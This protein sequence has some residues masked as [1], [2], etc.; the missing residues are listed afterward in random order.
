[1]SSRPPTIARNALP[2]AAWPPCSW[3]YVSS[4]SRSPIRCRGANIRASSTTATTSCRPTFASR[5]SGCSGV[6]CIPSIGWGGQW[7]YG[8][9]SWTIDYPRGDRHIAALVR[10]L[11]I[12]DARSVEQ[13]VNLDDG[14]DVF[15]W[16]WL[17]AVEV[18][19]GI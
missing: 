17:Y 11:S 8:G 15:N 9:T 16:P 3:A 18:G 10:R 2:A 4:A 13:P 19:N 7:Q 5:P 6:S 14:D 12:I 1:M